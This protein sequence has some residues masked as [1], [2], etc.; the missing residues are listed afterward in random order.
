MAGTSATV[1][2]SGGNVNTVNSGIT[3]STSAATNLQT[4]GASIAQQNAGIAVAAASGYGK[5][6][7]A[8]QQQVAAASQQQNAQLL[9]YGNGANSSSVSQA[10][11]SWG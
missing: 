10:I 11:G 9:T 8:V 1:N 5:E 7:T 4:G 3:V 6:S 2:I